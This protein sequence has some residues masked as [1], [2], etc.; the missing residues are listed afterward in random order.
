MCHTFLGH[1]KYVNWSRRATVCCNGVKQWCS[2]EVVQHCWRENGQIDAAKLGCIIS[3]GLSPLLWGQD[4]NLTWSEAKLL[5]FSPESLLKMSIWGCLMKKDFLIS[6]SGANVCGLGKAWR[7]IYDA[8]PSPPPSPNTFC[9]SAI[10]FSSRPLTK[11][12]AIYSAETGSSRLRPAAAC[13]SKRPA[14]H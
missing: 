7:Q 12:S 2:G 9:R 1:P 14:A 10:S 11:S 13:T 3:F 5:P 8:L 6:H 4:N